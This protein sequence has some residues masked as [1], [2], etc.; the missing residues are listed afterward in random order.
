MNTVETLNGTL[1]VIKMDITVKVTTPKGHAA[2]TAP[3]LRSWLLGMGRLKA[4]LK[5]DEENDSWFQWHIKNIDINRGLRIQRNVARYE[6]L[7]KGIMNNRGF[8]KAAR[9]AVGDE[10][11]EELDM[12]LLE[13]TKVEIVKEV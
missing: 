13:H 2:K 9:K 5:L 12:M 3:R 1:Q 8:K 4:T 7:I 11:M 10:G 6:I